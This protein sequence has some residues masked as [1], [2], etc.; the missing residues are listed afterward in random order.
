M[1]FSAHTIIA[2]AQLSNVSVSWTL[3]AGGAPTSVNGVLT[4]PEDTLDIGAVS[5][6]VT[7]P[8]LKVI[9]ADLP[10]GAAN[11]DTVLVNSTTYTAQRMHKHPSAGVTRITLKKP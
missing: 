4:N 9:T 8:M 1:D 11:G 5:F 3:A 7:Y 2:V 6:E 10:V